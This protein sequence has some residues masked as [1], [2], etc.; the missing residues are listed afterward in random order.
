MKNTGEWTS[1]LR[2]LWLAMFIAGL[3]GCAS[4]F[5]S[6]EGGRAFSVGWAWAGLVA[7]LGL[8]LTLRGLRRERAHFLRLLLSGM[9]IKLLAYATAV[10][11]VVGFSLLDREWFVG[12]L[13]SGMVVFMSIEVIAL[14]WRGAAVLVSS[15]R[16]GEAGDA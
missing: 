12:G 1:F 9:A 13:L 15:V 6:A 7:G 10:L 8:W 2:R 5:V 11:F 16:Q 14:V 4:V 3:P